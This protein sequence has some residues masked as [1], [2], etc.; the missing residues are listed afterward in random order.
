MAFVTHGILYILRFPHYIN[1]GLLVRG[2]S[3]YRLYDQYRNSLTCTRCG[4]KHYRAKLCKPCYKQDRETQFHCTHTHC[5]RPVFAATL[6]QK[7]YR[8]YKTKCLVCNCRYT[9]YRHLCRTHYRA[10]S[11]TGN[12][13]IEPICN[14]K[15]CSEKRFV[16]TKCL[17]HFKDQYRSCKVC[18]DEVYAKG[19]CCKHYFQARRKSTL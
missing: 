2:M 12:F 5:T 7:H 9:Y 4:N 8:S 11:Q 16:G 19:F 17:K 13:P 10:A 1:W 15:D 6:C 3:Y 14:V 18:K